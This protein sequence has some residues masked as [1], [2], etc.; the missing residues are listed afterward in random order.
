[1]KKIIPIIFVIDGGN[2]NVYGAGRGNITVMHN[3]QAM[4]F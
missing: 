3:G 2:V 1:M 4:G